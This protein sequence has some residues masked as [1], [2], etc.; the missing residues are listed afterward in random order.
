[1]AKDSTFDVV[2]KVDK[3]E[4]SNALNQAQK[5]IAQ[6]YDFRDV[7]ADIDFAGEGKL[8]IKANAEERAKA[9]LDVFQS[10][11]VKRGISLKSLEVGEPYASGKEVRIDASIKEG[12]D[13]ATAKKI[14]KLIRD[15]GPKSVKATIQGDELRVSSKSRDDL[16]ATIA[17]LKNFEDADLQFVNMR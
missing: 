6:R 14:S 2:S 16:Q 11:L 8:L 13:Q 4:V 17:L 10:K 15:E 9:V 3:Q 12:I 5:E 7:G 1:M